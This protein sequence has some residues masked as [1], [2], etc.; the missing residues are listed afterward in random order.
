MINPCSYGIEYSYWRV[1]RSLL[2]LH[3]HSGSGKTKPWKFQMEDEDLPEQK[4]KVPKLIPGLSYKTST[5]VTAP[6]Q[7]TA[8][9][10]PTPAFVSKAATSTRDQTIPW[11]TVAE[12]T[13]LAE[14][15][16]KASHHHHVEMMP[17]LQ[18]L[19]PWH[20]CLPPPSCPQPAPYAYRAFA[21]ACLGPVL[22][23][24]SPARTWQ[25]EGDS[26]DCNQPRTDIVSCSEEPAAPRRRRRR[27]RIRINPSQAERRRNDLNTP[28]P[29]NP[30]TS[31]DEEEELLRVRITRGELKR[32]QRFR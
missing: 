31:S 5:P 15:S 32:L 23:G 7:P 27:S 14:D 22:P 10:R 9:V 3:Y 8:A 19:H 11:E 1:K 25:H 13:G 6:S 20:H 4:Y 28:R 18:H 21:G 16:D 2:I 30:P 24:P 17:A 12:E 29:S 26:R